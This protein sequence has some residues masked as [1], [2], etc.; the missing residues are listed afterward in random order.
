MIKVV[1]WWACCF[2]KPQFRRSSEMRRPR[3]WACLT[4]L[5][6]Q[7]QPVSGW[8]AVGGYGDRINLLQQSTQPKQAE[9]AYDPRRILPARRMQS[10]QLLYNATHHCC[11]AS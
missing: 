5:D 10:P 6:K 4:E 1:P 8:L 7:S 2:L 11:P 9:A 3:P